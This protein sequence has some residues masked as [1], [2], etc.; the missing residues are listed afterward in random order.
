MTKM[1][2]IKSD[3]DTELAV[4]RHMLAWAEAHKK[5]AGD[6]NSHGYY[7]GCT[8]AYQGMEDRLVRLVERY[9]GGE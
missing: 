8:I 5:N 9:E 7:S 6:A 3:I 4:C 2:E 1:A